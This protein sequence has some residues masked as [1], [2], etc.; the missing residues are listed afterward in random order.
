LQSTV[1]GLS[2]AAISYYVVALFGHVAEGLHAKGVPIDT[3]VATAVF[4]P[5]AVLTIWWTV[6]RIRRKHIGRE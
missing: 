1:E 6:R 3:P 5:I 2:V 4:V